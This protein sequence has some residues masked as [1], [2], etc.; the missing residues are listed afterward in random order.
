MSIYIY[1][2]I[3]SLFALDLDDLYKRMVK[4]KDNIDYYSAAL[5][6]RQVQYTFV[7]L[8]HFLYFALYPKSF[9]ISFTAA[10]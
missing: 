9:M 2:Y 5:V 10:R 4:D 7:S 8:Y 3:Y 1:I 6:E